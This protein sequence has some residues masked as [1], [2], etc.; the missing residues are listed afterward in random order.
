MVAR[1]G[2][3]WMMSGRQGAGWWPRCQHCGGTCTGG[4]AAGTGWDDL[5]RAWTSARLPSLLT[6]PLPSPGGRDELRGAGH[7]QPRRR[8]HR[9]VAVRAQA[10]GR[11]L[12]R[13]PQ[14]APLELPGAR[15]GAGARGLPPP[16]AAAA[17]AAAEAATCR[18]PAWPAP[19]QPPV[20][21]LPA[22]WG[23]CRWR[24]RAAHASPRRPAS[25]PA[26]LQVR[27]F[28]DAALSCALHPSGHLIAVGGR[29]TQ[30]AAWARWWPPARRAALLA[31]AAG[32]RRH[33]AGLQP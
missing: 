6:P 19:R 21:H 13:G 17:P 1:M 32:L 30:R 2:W 31:S 24:V 20:V 23:C 29:P 3:Y 7:A 26:A 22:C 8:H 14:C 16:A 12:R 10:A 4:A 28:T 27:T 9:P 18:R 11:Q 15:R 33:W 5:G 25:P